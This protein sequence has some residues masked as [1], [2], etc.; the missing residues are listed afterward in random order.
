VW[1]ERVV[2]VLEEEGRVV[3]GVERHAIWSVGGISI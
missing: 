3:E 1:K 2:H